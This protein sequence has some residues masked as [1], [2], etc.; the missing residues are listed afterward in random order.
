M[1][2]VGQSVLD[3]ANS[4]HKDPEVEISLACPMKSRRLV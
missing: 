3:G 2:L 4:T 1:K